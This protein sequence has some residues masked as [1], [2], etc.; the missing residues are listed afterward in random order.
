[1]QIPEP[2]VVIALG[3]CACTGG[4]FR[5]MYNVENGVDRFIPVDV[6]VPGCAVRPEA[7]LKGIKKALELW[8]KKSKNSVEI[9][10]AIKKEYEETVAK[11]LLRG[12]NVDRRKI[13]NDMVSRYIKSNFEEV[14]CD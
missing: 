2:K 12:E 7:I 6:Y 9:P 8:E 14:E 4:A 13:I 5:H 11:L 10:T 1:M 3:T